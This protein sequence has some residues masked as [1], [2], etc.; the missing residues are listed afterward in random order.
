MKSSLT[1]KVLLIFALAVVGA[2]L[3]YIPPRILDQYDKIKEL[4]PPWTYLYFGLVGSGAFILFGLAGTA[5]W[6]IWKNTRDKQQ[7]RDR[8]EKNPS[9]LSAGEKQ[10]E[11]TDNLAAVEQLHSDA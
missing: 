2:L 9:Q 10:Q 4:G 8:R 6:R 1:D 7:K 3:V 5:V 11:L